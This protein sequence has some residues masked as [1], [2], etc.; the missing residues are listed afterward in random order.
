MIAPAIA[1]KDLS[2]VSIRIEHL[3]AHLKLKL[4]RRE[5]IEGTQ[6]EFIPFHLFAGTGA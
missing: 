6:H 1:P 5:A 2:W 4:R 3:D